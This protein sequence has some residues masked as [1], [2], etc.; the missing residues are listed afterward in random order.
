MKNLLRA[1]FVIFCYSLAFTALVSIFAGLIIPDAVRSRYFDNL[2]SGLTMHFIGP[3]WLRM[4]FQTFVVVV[5][6]LM[7]SGALNTAII[8][9][10]AVLNRVSEDGVLVDW[11][12]MPHTKYGTTHRLI[13]LVCLLQLATIILSRGEIYLLGEAYAFGIAWSFTMNGLSM[14]VLRFKDKQPREW[15]VPGNIQIGKIEIPVGIAAIALALFFI[16]AINLV[17]KQVATVSGVALTLIF[18][19]I[20]TISEHINRKKR[21]EGEG[22]LEHFSLS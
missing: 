12:R 3:L 16:A 7:L 5:G 18:F 2:I 6:F 15:K 13:N 1:A 19:T 11:F 4:A 17:T 22:A 8:G 9:S 20:F 10:N 21:E 14:L